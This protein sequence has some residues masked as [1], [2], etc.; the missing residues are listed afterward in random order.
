MLVTYIITHN[1]PAELKRLIKNIVFSSKGL[2]NF[3]CVIVDSSTNEACQNVNHELLKSEASHY[4]IIYNK[5]DKMISPKG[6]QIRNKFVRNENEIGWLRNIILHYHRNNFSDFD[7]I[8]LDDDMNYIDINSIYREAQIL[9]KEQSSFIAGLNIYGI[10]SRDTITRIER[11]LQYLSENNERSTIANLNINQI[12]FSN[13]KKND[14]DFTSRLSGGGLYLHGCLNIFPWFPNCYNES[15]IFCKK[16]NLHGIPSVRMISTAIHDPFIID[17]KTIEEM[18]FEQKG[19]FLE[20]VL[21]YTRDELALG[22]D[23]ISELTNFEKI[24]SEKHPNIRLKNL[25]WK[26]NQIPSSVFAFVWKK[27]CK[28]EWMEFTLKYK[29]IDWHKE[30]NAYYTNFIKN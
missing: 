8:M 29:E 11:I 4:K 21:F 5:P 6:V 17:R 23:K 9:S 7:C 22:K 26:I 28:E 16:A 14:I 25:L 2:D 27:F 3:L 15:W 30:L 20:R 13:L 10:D 12:L 19:I 18:I 1:R 24:F